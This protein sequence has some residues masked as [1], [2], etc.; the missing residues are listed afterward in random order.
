MTIIHLS[1]N[2]EPQERLQEHPEEEFIIR[3]VGAREGD[4]VQYNLPT[5]DDLAMLVVMDFS[6]ETFKRDIVIETR[7]K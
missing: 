4:A 3:I 2:L 5:T 6:L 1:R 7:N